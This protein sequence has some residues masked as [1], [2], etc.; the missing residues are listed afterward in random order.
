MMRIASEEV[1]VVLLP[2]RGGRLHRLRAFGHDLLRTPDSL[3]AYD[4]EP[5]FWGGFV[6]APWC[7]RIAP[8][9]IQV[10]G[11]MVDLPPNFADGTAIHGQVHDRHWAVEPDGMLRVE[12]GGDGW[13]WPYEVT[14]RVVVDGTRLRMEHVLTN[15]A[16][17]PMPAGLGI[18]PWF[19]RPLEVAI[20]ADQVYPSNEAGTGRPQPVAGTLDLRR[21]GPMPPDLDATWVRSPG[22][23]V[24]LRWPDLG[25]DA[26]MAAGPEGGYVCAASPGQIDAVAVEPQTHA[27]G[28]LRRLLAGVDGAL[29]RLPPG[30]SLRLDV[31]LVFRRDA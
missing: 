7:N 9:S 8:G 12:A 15:R 23:P 3:D 18:H 30:A 16:D 25:V 26:R 14:L 4:H 24:V 31:E 28:G 1:D 17:G 21:L 6:M 2:E 27:S 22:E 20:P 19:R 29:T 10:A 5:F 13:P 11:R